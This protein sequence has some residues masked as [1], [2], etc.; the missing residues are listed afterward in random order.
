MCTKSINNNNNKNRGSAILTMWPRL[1][2]FGIF[3]YEKAPF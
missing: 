1:E 2:G 3:P